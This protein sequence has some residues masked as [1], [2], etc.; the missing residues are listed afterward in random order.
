MVTFKTSHQRLELL[1]HLEG[2]S[3]ACAEALGYILR[4]K[5]KSR[6]AMSVVSSDI[7]PRAGTVS[8]QLLLLTEVL[9]LH[10]IFSEIPK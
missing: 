7:K 10:L 4:G 8:P 1:T 3:L 2:V 5:M 6:K 9:P